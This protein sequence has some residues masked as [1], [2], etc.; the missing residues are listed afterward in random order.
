MKRYFEFSDSK[1]YKFWQIEVAEATCTVKYGKIGTEGQEKVSTFDSAEKAQKEADKLVAEK[2]RKGYVEKESASEKKT[3]RRIAVDYDEAEEGKTLLDKVI[4]FAESAQ[5]ATTT[6][7]VIGSWEEAYESS[8]QEALDYLAVN[9]ARLPCLTE[10]FVGDMDSEECEISWIN[11]GNYTALIKAFPQ[12]ER[13]HIKGS[14]EL[15]LSSEP[16][17]HANLKALTI[18]C[19]G[20][21]KSI[22]ETI[23][24]AQLPNLEYLNLYLG[25]DEYGFDASLDDLRP[26]LTKERFPKLKYLALADSEIADEIAEA[27][28]EAPV[29]DILETLDLSQGTLSDKGGEALLASSKIRQLKRLDL[30]YHY[31]SNAVMAKLR[32][33]GPIVDVTEQQDIEDEWRYPAVTE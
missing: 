12:L 28:A 32:A 3:S 27:I 2:T 29:L 4:A 20:L 7:L 17:A 6:A 23:T 9:S 18:E 15:V 31:L 5:A 13:L 25:V 1:S 22:I 21:P 33:L 19:G 26:L 24:Q 30:H 14:T 8:C 11:Q 16:L 10:L